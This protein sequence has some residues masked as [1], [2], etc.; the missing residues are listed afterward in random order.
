M[1]TDYFK[2]RITPSRLIM[3]DLENGPNRVDDQDRVS[4]VLKELGASMITRQLF[5]LPSESK[6]PVQAIRDA[7]D[8]ILRGGDHAV[9]LATA[10]SGISI[11]MLA[12]QNT[13]EGVTV[14]GRRGHVRSD[15]I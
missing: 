5:T 9:M 14:Q 7:L 4:K 8:P 15:G 11:S 3:V 2:V 12:P 13:T 1:G 6:V 10:E